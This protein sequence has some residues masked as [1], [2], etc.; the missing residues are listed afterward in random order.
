MKYVVIFGSALISRT[1]SDID[2]VFS[3]MSEHEAIAIV[4]KW[5]TMETARWSTPPSRLHGIEAH[6]DYVKIPCRDAGGAFSLSILGAPTVAFD[7]VLVDNPMIKSVGRTTPYQRAR[8]A[9]YDSELLSSIMESSYR[10][11]RYR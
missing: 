9:K 10:S 5:A 6:G 2:F 11:T 3:E 1:P 4:S 8:S 7:P